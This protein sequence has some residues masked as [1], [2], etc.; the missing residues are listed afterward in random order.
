[1]A[2]QVGRT[3]DG[4][5]RRARRRGARPGRA[6]GLRRHAAR[7]L[8]EAAPH[9]VR[10]HVAA[11]RRQQG[12]DGHAARALRR[13]METLAALLDA[14]AAR[15]P[16]REALACAPRDAVTVRRTWTELAADSHRAA[17]TPRAAGARQG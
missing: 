3:G 7:R 4:G 14:T 5:G 15:F 6:R 1:A 12:A 8:Q 13:V 17:G 11:E 16:A 10:G 9:R 2:P